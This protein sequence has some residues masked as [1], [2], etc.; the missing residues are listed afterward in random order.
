M[1]CVGYRQVWEALDAHQAVGLNG[2]LPMAEVRELGIIATR[3]LAKRQITWLRSMPH[4]QVV[5]ADSANALQNVL[6][7]VRQLLP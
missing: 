2:P 1:R 5:Q 7:L 4:R 3:Q 6:A